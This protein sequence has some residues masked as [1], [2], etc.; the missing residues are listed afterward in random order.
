MRGRVFLLQIPLVF[1]LTVDS[2]VRADV[3]Q[4]EADRDNTLYE[5]M[6]GDISN[7]EGN[8]VFLGRTGPDGDSLVRRALVHFDLSAIPADVIIDSVE[9]SFEVVAVPLPFNANGGTATLHRVSADWGEGGSN[10]PGAEGQG[11]EAQPGDATWQYRFHDTV[12]WNSPGGDYLLEA[13][14]SVG[15]GTELESLAFAST[16]ELVQDVQRW[17]NNPAQNFGWILLGS[18]ILDFTARKMDSKDRQSGFPALLTVDYHPEG[19]TDNLALELVTS[20][21]NGPVG[22]TNAG[23][24]SNRLFIVE[25]SGFIRIYDLEA[26]T[27]LGTPFLNISSLVDDAGGEQG[28]LGLAFHPDFENNRQFYVN[29]TYDP[30]AGLDRTRIAMYQASLGNPNIADTSEAVILEFEQNATNHNGGD[31]HFDP[32]GY[33]V[34]A[35][36]DGGGSPGTRAQNPD[37]LVGKMLRID[38][39]PGPMPQGAEELC[40]LVQNYSIPA[41]NAFPGTNDG[42][43]EILH[44]GMRNPWRFS[45]DAKTG[46]MYIGDVGQNTWEEVDYAA[47]GEAGINYG[48]P[49]CEG[50]HEYPPNGELCNEPGFRNPIIEYGHV[51]G[52][53]SIAGGYV[54]RGGNTSLQGRYVYA[55]SYSRRIWIATRDG[56]N[57]TSEEWIDS[58]SLQFISTFGQNETCELYLADYVAGSIYRFVN[59]EHIDSSGFETLHCQ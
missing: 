30:E 31:L 38:V 36:G 53:Q 14:A 5:D 41:G 48:W 1:A 15:Y 6:Q 18:E 20:G 24:G 44:I 17:V 54:Y 23:D 47:P 22:I 28:L 43:D 16:P 55:D 37:L 19:P 45:F 51:A 7:G 13:S 57:W 39:D 34:I 52:N 11:I 21:L 2:A 49:D 9:I 46:E 40:G 32:D 26:E 3:M 58:P 12:P 8:Y 59:S 4:F 25:R 50:A 27:L 42:C 29:Y 33:L 10:A 35:S 56:D